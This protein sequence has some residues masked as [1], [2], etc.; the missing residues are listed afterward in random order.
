MWSTSSHN[1][2]RA[3]NVLENKDKNLD[4]C[5]IYRL[6]ENKMVRDEKIQV[7]KV[8][9]VSYFFSRRSYVSHSL[10]LPQL[11]DYVQL[12]KDSIN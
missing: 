7:K 9:T 4:V 12:S 10:G 6:K 5:V 11:F 1:G 8:R 2:E 3:S